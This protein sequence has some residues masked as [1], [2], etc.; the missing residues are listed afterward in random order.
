MS[1]FSSD[2]LHVLGQSPDR[3]LIVLLMDRVQANPSA[4]AAQQ[5]VAQ[6]LASPAFQPGQRTE[7]VEWLLHDWLV[8]TVHT[9]QFAWAKALLDQGVN[10]SLMTPDGA[11]GG[12][13]ALREALDLAHD[14]KGEPALLEQ[15]WDRTDMHS[16]ITVLMHRIERTMIEGYFG[17]FSDRYVHH[18]DCVAARHCNNPAVADALHAL[19]RRTGPERLPLYRQQTQA[20]GETTGA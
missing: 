16:M 2:D 9:R 1:V 4:D 3:N 5:G 11:W 12:G 13:Q 14:G 17:W 10:P 20:A 19:I 18:V 7:A 6:L 8:T 15:L